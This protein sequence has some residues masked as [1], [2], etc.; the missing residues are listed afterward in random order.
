MPG[1]C[2]DDPDEIAA[3]RRQTHDALIDLTRSAKRRGPIA[4]REVRGGGLC[5]TT[6]RALYADDDRP[7]TRD[8][9]DLFEAFFREFPD[10]CVL[11]VATADVVV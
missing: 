1:A 6:L 9:L 8:G 4:W 2:I 11:I 3:M 7:V 10:D 5:T